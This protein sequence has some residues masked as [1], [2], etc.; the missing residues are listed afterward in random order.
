MELTP[1][2]ELIATTHREPGNQLLDESVLQQSLDYLSKLPETTHLFCDPDAYPVTVHLMILYTFGDSDVLRWFSARTA[3]WLDVCQRCCCMFHRGVAQLKD[4]FVMIRGIAVPQVREFIDI[5]YDHHAARLLPVLTAEAERVAAEDSTTAT[6]SPRAAL[7]LADMLSGPHLFRRSATLK[8]CFSRLFN[9][10]IVQDEF[11]K[12]QILLPGTLYLL[13]DGTL[14]ERLWALN[15]LQSFRALPVSPDDWDVT[16]TEEYALH[17]WRIQ[18]PAFYTED[19]AT[20]FWKNTTAI[21]HAIAPATFAYLN[22]PRDIDCVKRTTTYDLVPV[23]CVLRNHIMSFC[24]APLPYALR[25]LT[26]FLR[27]LDTGFWPLVAPSTFLN[28]LDTILAN[29]EFARLGLTLTADEDDMVE[30]RA[31][32]A[33][34]TAWMGPLFEQLPIAQQQQ[35]GI[36]LGMA[37]LNM[38]PVAAVAAVHPNA[39]YFTAHGLY[40]LTQCLTT[41]HV[42]YD[43]QLTIELMTRAESR[44]LVDTQCER[45]LTA[46]TASMRDTFDMTHADDRVRYYSVKLVAL[47]FQYDVV[48]FAQSRYF[49]HTEGM[50]LTSLV[51]PRL[52]GLVLRVLSSQDHY[53]IGE[54]LCVFDNVAGVLPFEFA[55][56]DTTN[57]AKA[58]YNAHSAQLLA[59]VENVLGKV[60]YLAPARLRAL[61]ARERVLEG[62]WSCLLCANKEV[63]IYQAA[64]NILYEAFDVQGRR[65]GTKELLSLNLAACLAALNVT[66]KRIMF[67]KF[68]E[69]C[70][71][72]VRVL[73]DVV[74]ALSDPLSGIFIDL[75]TITPE[76]DAALLDFWTICWGF[77]DVIYEGT[78]KWAMQ[79]LNLVEFTRDTL[80]LSLSVFAAFKPLLTVL[81]R[82]PGTAETRARRLFADIMSCFRH[83]LVWLRLGDL[84]L[85]SS[86]VELIF[87]TV[88]L[89][90]EL[91]LPF[92]DTIVTAIARY[93]AKAKKFNNKLSTQQRADILD[94]AR[95]FNEG[96]VDEVVAEAEGYRETKLESATPV[97]ASPEPRATG[98][99]LYTPRAPAVRAQPKITNFA[100]PTTVPP[101][102]FA[103]KPV[104]KTTALEAIRLERAQAAKKLQLKPKSLAAP[105][106]P[107]PAGFNKNHVESS[108]ESDADDV[109]TTDLFV[110]APAAKPK[111]SV[112][113]PVPSLRRAHVTL[114]DSQRAEK[115][116][117]L[118]LNVDMSPLYAKI[119]KWNVASTAEFPDNTEYTP[120]GETFASVAEYTR[121]FEP[122]LLL[123]CWQ[124]MVSAKQAGSDEPFKLVV[125]SRTTL[126]NFFDVYLLVRKDV[127]KE[128]RLGDTDMLVLAFVEEAQLD[129]AGLPSRATM[130]TAAAACLGKI[131]EIKH[132]GEYCDL[133]IRVS[134]SNPLLGFLTPRAELF[135]MK[136][137][138]MVTVERE[139]AS[140][141]GLAYYDLADEVVRATPCE[142]TVRA[143][144]SA[145]KRAYDVN[146]SQ[147]AAIAGAVGAEGFSL[148]QGPPGTG[149]TKTI[150]GIIG[151]VLTDGAKNTIKADSRAAT[152]SGSGRRILVCAPSNAAVDELVL[153]I[154]AGVR[155]ANGAMFSPKVVRLGRSDAINSAVRD[156]TLEEL[157]DA[158]IAS[159]NATVQADPKIREEHNKCVAERDQLRT[160]LARGDLLPEAALAAESQLREVN[161]RRHQLGKQLDDQRERISVSHR[162]REI[163]RRQI[164]SQ[165]LLG[166][167]VICATLSGSAHDFVAALGMTFETVVIDEAAQCI[168]LS[169][170]IPLRY[171]CKKCIMVGDPNQLP[172]TVLSQAAARLR[173]EQ[174]LFVRMQTRHP[175]L[176]YLLDVQYRMHPDISAFPS[177]EF[178]DSRLLNGPD[179]ARV[180]ARAWHAYAP[181]APYRFFDIGGAHQQNALTKSLFNMAEARAALDLFA[182]VESLCGEMAGKVGV[183]S[184]YKEQVRRI[185]DVFVK[186]YGQMILHEVDFNTVDGFQGQEKEIIIM[187]CVRGSDAKGVGFVGDVRRMN[188]ALTRAKSSMWVLG[189]RESLLVNKMWRD[190]VADAEERGCVEVVGK[191]FCKKLV[192]VDELQS[193]VNPHP[194]G[195]IANHST[196]S[197][198]RKSSPPKPGSN[199]T[200]APHSASSS[201]T[202]LQPPVKSELINIVASANLTPV[203]KVV[204]PVDPPIRRPNKS[205]SVDPGDQTLEEEKRL[206]KERKRERKKKEWEAK[207]REEL[208]PDDSLNQPMTGSSANRPK[209]N[210]PTGDS[211]VKSMA[212]PTGESK[213]DMAD[214]A[215]LPLSSGVMKRKTDNSLPEAKRPQ[216]E[217]SHAVKTSRVFMPK[218]V[219]RSTS[220]YT[221]KVYEAPSANAEPPLLPARS[222]NRKPELYPTR[223]GYEQYR[224]SRPNQTNNGHLGRYEPQVRSGTLPPRA[225]YPVPNVSGGVMSNGGSSRGAHRGRGRGRGTNVPNIF[226]KRK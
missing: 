202:V 16:L 147:A 102:Q 2:L 56:Q 33:D 109:D 97:R 98:G 117:R 215:P 179:M 75:G 86:C 182:A 141:K 90:L 30:P 71:K 139:Y 51:R 25:T 205:E 22:R 69:P 31:T 156:L 172:P 218:Q 225:G 68:F 3:R 36:K 88:D 164:Q 132:A 14:Q 52:W 128:K 209:T 120:V 72:T 129:S 163:A 23:A 187:S 35:A 100:T 221:P 58:D 87:A 112:I 161:K 70:P 118:R 45:I 210:A 110:K 220:R 12:P 153:R 8:Q 107:R 6:L 114:T 59:R 18:D 15:L 103:T 122:L 226:I 142:P 93:G 113:G 204:I 158:K 133:T 123:E 130:K 76:L 57:R 159:G 73:M 60:S 151:C 213:K 24:G 134:N 55:Q 94:R 49:L 222:S 101:F 61:F 193:K 124:Q 212:T 108:D 168:E 17:L 29:P 74:L 174:S 166:A 104:F 92:D 152:S 145:K 206:K 207:E 197:R 27:L 224:E 82:E 175:Q 99:S 127:L 196:D 217:V 34:L 96:I 78:L 169:A 173:Y 138:Q 42:L 77:L 143:D 40:Y 180:T 80:D 81:A 140:L 136:I 148:I 39:A 144:V 154:R 106:A 121:T 157:V 195:S 62:L 20:A 188:V 191:G 10:T 19:H 203:E 165:I 53:F 155:D 26:V 64:V 126:N 28:F 65:E 184:P 46:A 115:N 167:E 111:V 67:L 5:I 54:L 216:N 63:D 84:S 137:M 178:Y 131:R 38:V 183:I 189:N 79:Y 32:L 214:S 125:G 192:K 9:L 83:M 4:N 66:L 198:V 190:L 186:R 50:G 89:A 44:N 119:L 176:V 135:A 116:M 47:A 199:V 211:T 7:A 162:N 160:A 91:D 48:A 185:R 105:A 223:V 37:L 11:I 1:L 146:D 181:L 85:L 177:R 21:A 171:G 13:F 43:K 170:L 201:S 41:T 150:L 194:T 200:L 95:K 208:K 219:P 149:K